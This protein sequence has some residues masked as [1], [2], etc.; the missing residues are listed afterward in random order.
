MWDDLLSEETILERV[1]AY[2]I[3]SFYIGAEQEIGKTYLSVLRKNSIKSDTKPSFSLFWYGKALMFKDFG[4]GLSGNVFTFVKYLFSY[5][6][7]ILVLS[8]I[9]SDFK[10]E[11]DG[12]VRFP[13]NGNDP[14]IC[15]TPKSRPNLEAIR[16]VSKRKFTMKFLMFWADYG[17]KA[18]TLR[19][20][21]I[22]EVSIIYFDYINRHTSTIYPKT[23]CAGY[24]IYEF[25]KLYFPFDKGNKFLNNYPVDYVE[26]FLQLKYEK[27]F[28]II[29]KSTK[30]VLFFREHFDWDSVAGKSESTTIT[31]FIILKLL[32]KFKKLYIWLDND[33]T[34]QKF[35]KKYCEE[36]PFL[37]SIYYN[38]QE[39]DPTD[40]YF[41]NEDKELVLNEIKKLIN[42]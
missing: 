40:R 32:Q 31:K 28:C 5:E 7:L 38:V 2:S 3:Y 26:G 9:N 21:D 18:K 4:N 25:Y 19:Y 16:I 11:L 39:K 15:A 12:G 42:E 30:E 23:L 41:Y 8:R 22:K 1:D 36:Y 14:K 20:Y 37:I 17:I 29:T 10:L 33:I 24:P 13:V 27:D 6:S 35:Q 34:G